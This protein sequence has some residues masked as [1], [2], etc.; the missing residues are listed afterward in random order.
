MSLVMEILYD[1]EDILEI[2]LNEIYLGQKA[3]VS[4]NGVGEASFFYYGKP[5]ADLS[6]SEGA[7]IAGLIKGPNGYSPYV[8]KQRCNRSQMIA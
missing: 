3:S 8:N 5:V 7:V 2:Y 6:L 1:K 4:I